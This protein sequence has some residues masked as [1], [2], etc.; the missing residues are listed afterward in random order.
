MTSVTGAVDVPAITAVIP[1]RDRGDSVLMPL[2]TLLENEYPAFEVRIVDQSASDATA[3]VVAPCLSDPRV[4]YRRTPSQ[5]LSA[6]LNEGVRGVRT[7]LVAITGDDCEVRRDWLERLVA[8]FSVDRGPAV[9]FGNVLPGPHDRAVGFVPGS[10][11]SAPVL[12]RSVR[13]KYRLSGTSACMAFR[14]TVWQALDGFDEMLG[15]GAPLQAGEDTDFV[16]RALLAGHSVYET[17][18]ATVV[19]HGLVRWDLR[20]RLIHRNWYGT[21]AAFAKALKRGD[22]RVLAALGRLAWNWAF[23]G[24]Q[25]AGS[26]GDGPYR[27][28]SLAA[29]AR[30][31]AAGTLLPVDRRSGHFRPRGTAGRTGGSGRR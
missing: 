31:F 23:R 18:E 28:A 6:A 9:I 4:L 17:P 13:D 16:I 14:R 30:G 3:R 7:E 15:V 5:G 1:T 29:F 20:A 8:G 10:V 22:R 26:L 2:R 27:V 25:V 11:R 19:H 12:V 21:G 24:S